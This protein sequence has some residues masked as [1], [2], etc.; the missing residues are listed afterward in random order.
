MR[1]DSSKGKRGKLGRKCYYGEIFL[2]VMFPSLVEARGSLTAGLS[3]R[4]FIVG[5]LCAAQIFK[6]SKAPGEV[7]LTVF[8]RA[9]LQSS[10]NS[11]F[12]NVKMA[13]WLRYL[14]FSIY[15]VVAA[16]PCPFIAGNVTYT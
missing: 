15:S 5:S 1:F 3:V 14:W 2:C 11:Y 16:L 13:P 4:Q 8:S 9:Y 12:E 10:S 6:K 7:S